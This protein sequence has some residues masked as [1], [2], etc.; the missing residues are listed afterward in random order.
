MSIIDKLQPL[1]VED[2]NKDFKQSATIG[3]Y[4]VREEIGRGSF[5][6]VKKGR[7]S[8]KKKLVA[9]KI[10]ELKKEVTQDEIKREAAHMLQVKGH[11]HILSLKEVICGSGCMCL[12]LEYAK[13]GDLQTYVTSKGKLPEYQARRYF[14]QIAS[15][16]RHC[17]QQGIVH[18]DI[19]AENIFLM[20][21]SVVKIGDFGFSQ[22]CKAGQNISTFCGS[23]HYAAPEIFGEDCYEGSA[24]DIWAL[25]VLLYFL[26]AGELPFRACD[27][28]GICQNIKKAKY[29]DCKMSS[30]FRALI[31]KIIVPTPSSRVD[32]NSVCN[33][34]WTVTVKKSMR[35]EKDGLKGKMSKSD[36][37]LLHIKKGALRTTRG[38]K[39]RRRQRSFKPIS[40]VDEQAPMMLNTYPP[41]AC[42]RGNLSKSSPSYL[43]DSSE[44]SQSP[45]PP[46]VHK[47]QVVPSI[48]KN[49]PHTVRSSVEAKEFSILKLTS[50]ELESIKNLLEAKKEL[51]L[52][53]INDDELQSAETKPV[54]QL[55]LSAPT[56]ARCTHNIILVSTGPCA[57]ALRR[58]VLATLERNR[59]ESKDCETP[60]AS[61]LNLKQLPSSV[62]V[63][64]LTDYV[65]HANSK[66]KIKRFIKR[67]TS[68]KKPSQPKGL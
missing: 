51:S 61:L 10:I 36:S 43:Y 9:L 30:S 68:R 34:P 14:S 16:V 67:K 46:P 6:V 64:G 26:I 47:I 2:R 21:S 60:A 44:A 49:K 39:K 35:G 29:A 24:V 58:E 41:N 17:H 50:Q 28:F 37:E 42:I 12:V 27:D 1:M 55:S 22:E 32:I 18:A 56:V 7:H 13:E 11:A 54:R 3:E 66:E 4:K 53:T 59:T 25:G 57:E 48:R 38:R 40:E 15:G 23:L 5:S 33:D 20:S 45:T 19:K 8:S 65:A 62:S 52:L 31:N 63:D